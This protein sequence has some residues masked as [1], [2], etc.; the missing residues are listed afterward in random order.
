MRV[1]DIQVDGF[2]VWKGLKIDGVSENFT[3]FYGQ[4]EAGKTTLMQFIRSIMFG[5]SPERRKK[6]IPPVYGG[7]AGGSLHVI[8]PHSDY[9]IERH[10]DPNRITDPI[11]D[12]SVIDAK[13]G[14]VHGR[15][16]LGNVLS[17][18]DESIFNNVFA[19]GLREIQELNALNSTDA[20]EHLYK[21]TSG[22]DRVSL[23]DVMRDLR[24]RREKIWSSSEEKPGRLRGLTA[25]RRE[26][27]LEIDELMSRSRR[28]SKIAVQTSE[29]NQQIEEIDEQV[30]TLEHEA[31]VLEVAIQIGDRW[32]SRSL[33]DDQ[34]ATFGTLPKLNEISVEELDRL[35]AR[36]VKHRERISLIKKQ[37]NE[38]RREVEQLPINRPVWSQAARIDAMCEHLPWIESMQRQIERLRRG[39]AE[40]TS[41]LGGEVDGLGSK[42]NL[43]NKDIREI[44]TRSFSTLRESGRKMLDQKELVNKSQNEVDRAKLE[45][46]QLE[47]RLKS[48]YSAAQKVSTGTIDDTGRLVTRLRRRIE[49]EEKI[50]KLNQTRHEL[51]R[52]IDDVVNEQ[53]LPVGKLT[54]LGFIF[55][56]GVIFAGFGLLS[57]WWTRGIAGS[58]STEV[59]FLL[60]ILGTGFGIFSLALKHH[61]E[62]VAREELD[63]FRHQFDLVRQQLKRAKAERDEIDRHIPAGAGE[64]NLQLKEAEGHLARLED[65]MPM[66]NRCKTAKFQVEE[67][68]RH[69]TRVEAEY[70][71]AKKNWRDVLRN[72]G[73]PDTLQPSDIDGITQKSERI[74]GFHNRLEQY[75][76][77][78]IERETEL[79]SISKRVDTL[80]AECDLSFENTSL[81]ERVERLRNVL[82]D[83]R[84]LI[85]SRK[86]HAA[87]YKSLRISY[88][89]I[90]RE[91]ERTLG[92]KR[93]LL[94]AVA[95][96][97]EDDYR[98][99][100]T[101]HK[102]RAKLVD[103]RDQLS[104]QIAAALTSSV[105]E[106]KIAEK[107]AQYGQAGLERRKLKSTS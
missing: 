70:E 6:Y 106:Q 97:T 57:W 105:T 19:I 58:T 82:G 2:G 53:V 63:D 67:A 13:D 94:A 74:S 64:W 34:I 81:V 91:I 103:K 5:F 50:E 42:L 89:K 61:W 85:G 99:F 60:M 87:K 93:K 51:E 72:V 100:Q 83:Q 24:A 48:T 31:K 78:L 4:N 77:E 79:E 47:E 84:R 52:D 36:L 43:T 49:L 59:G 90:S 26:L 9:E 56:L 80:I 28:W 8:T 73:L 30:S 27:M 95:A 54:T 15:A 1:N 88:G 29:I 7:L 23:V 102:Q 71:Q 18:I 3:L 10:I 22:L 33:L 98:A 86:E 75:K 66:E 46:S 68:E 65:L 38:L 41:T 35:N 14:T 62:R 92:L 39:I 45:L 44:A 96:E 25:R 17:D 12:L 104:D 76:A 32:H 69:R 107:M 101:K 37:R 21:L 55:I 11:G 16:T 20:A 40:L